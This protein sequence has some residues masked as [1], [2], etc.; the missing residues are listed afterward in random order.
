MGR[1]AVGVDD[2]F[3]D[4]LLWLITVVPR[5]TAYAL[6]GLQSGVLQNYAVTM[7]GGAAVILLLVF[8]K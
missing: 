1:F 8:W 4:G 5:A 3:I 6:R 7:V 2:F